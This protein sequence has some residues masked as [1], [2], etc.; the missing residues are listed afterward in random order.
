V[1]SADKKARE[2]ARRA[3]RGAGQAGE[4]IMG[5]A[6]L[7][8]D[9][10]AEASQSALDVEERAREFNV[11]RYGEAKEYL[12]PYIED[13]R[14]AQ[15]QMMIEMG[16]APGEAGTAYMQT[17]GYQ[18]AI[19]EGTRA[20][21]TG[22]AGAG[23]L[24]SGARGGALRD[25]GAGVQNQYYTNYMDRLQNIASPNAAQS[26]GAMGVNQGMA[27][28]G[29]QMGAQATASGY[30]M[31]GAGVGFEA[32][33]MASGYNLE[34]IAATNAASADRASMIPNLFSSYLMGGGSIG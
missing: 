1:Y 26:L 23:M 6:G 28:G 19:D 34:G 32:Q 30:A 27:M 24:Y 12:S 22:A 7:Y 15:N 8:Q 21:N 16:L 10:A 31:Q 9:T 25:V 11:Q 14:T 4:D 33:G 29:Q 20:V 2:A 17:P 13:S 5:A 18:S 3:R